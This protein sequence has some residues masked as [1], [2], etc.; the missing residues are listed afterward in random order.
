MVLRPAPARF[1]ILRS[2]HPLIGETDPGSLVS[3]L[4][5]V[6][7][8]LG[9]CVPGSCSGS[10]ICCQV[11]QYHVVTGSGIRIWGSDVGFTSP[12]M[13]TE[14]GPQDCDQRVPGE[15]VSIMPGAVGDLNGDGIPEI[16][17]S[18][19]TSARILD[20]TGELLLELPPW[21]NGTESSGIML[22]N[23]DD[24][25]Y[26]EIV[27]GRNV[28]FLGDDGS[29]GFVVTHHLTASEPVDAPDGSTT[30]CIGDLTDHPGQ[31]LVV[32]ASLFALRG[33]RRA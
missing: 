20:N 25:G 23:L 1:I 18:T 15:S 19:S 8:S 14:C 5:P 22:A 4:E 12:C 17:Y 28:Y 13:G 29:G 3:V 2:R 6:T 9:S 32:G 10:E 24:S 30:T 27:G 31:E 11:C 21:E 33:R 7:L 16:V 26:A